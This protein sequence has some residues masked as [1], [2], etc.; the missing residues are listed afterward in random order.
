MQGYKYVTLDSWLASGDNELFNPQSVATRQTRPNLGGFQ[1][2]EPAF[3][4]SGNITANEKRRNV[5]RSYLH[6][7]RHFPLSS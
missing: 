6:L 5:L 4:T 2:E 7:E 3:I 1:Y